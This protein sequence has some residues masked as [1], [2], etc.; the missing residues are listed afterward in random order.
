MKKT[1]FVF[2]SVFIFSTSVLADKTKGELDSVQK[3]LKQAQISLQNKENQKNQIEKQ[4]TLINSELQGYENKLKKTNLEIQRNKKEITNL[5]KKIQIKTN[6]ISK[7]KKRVADLLNYQYKHEYPSAL[8]LI[9]QNGNPNDKTRNLEYLKYIQETQQKSFL[10]LKS[11]QEE[12]HILE[13]SLQ[14]KLSDLNELAEKN[15]KLAKQAKVKKEQQIKLKKSMEIAIAQD[16]NKIQTLKASENKLNRLIQDLAKQQREKEQQRQLA[17]QSKQNKTPKTTKSSQQKNTQ[18]LGNLTQE[19]LHLTE[20]KR[21]NIVDSSESLVNSSFS[22]NRGLLNLPVRGGIITQHYGQKR[23]DGGIVKGFVIKS[24]QN[25]PVFSVA[26]GTVVYRGIMPDYGNTVVIMH[27][28]AYVTI[29]TG[30]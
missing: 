18:V 9:M 12:L 11:E 15:K 16:K 5:E 10:T 25:L 1:L 20:S 24:P 27:D 22:K 26:D 30:L 23:D 2:L 21:A 3:E 29:Y 6:E 14:K 17:L 19:D 28:N 13:N 4:L 8:V 7:I